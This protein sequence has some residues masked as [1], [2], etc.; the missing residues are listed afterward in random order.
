MNTI[1]NGLSI[2]YSRIRGFLSVI[3]LIVMISASIGNWHSSDELEKE[4]E[5]SLALYGSYSDW[6]EV[7]D[8]FPKYGKAVVMDLD[9][10]LSFNVQRRGGTYHADVQ[11]VTEEDTGIMKQIYGGKW[12]WKRRAVLVLVGD[13]R[14]AGSMNGMPHGGGLIRGNGFPGHFCIHFK[15]SRLHI[16]GNEDLAHRIM[17]YKASG[18][19]ED[20][21]SG[22]TKEEVVRILFT[23]M[24]QEE[25]SITVRT[26]YFENSGDLADFLNKAS[27]ISRIRVG[28]VSRG[29]GD[30]VNVSLG[31]EFKNGKKVSKKEKTVNTV[32]RR[33]LGWRVDYRSVQS[34]L[35]LDGE[36]VQDI[37]GIAG[38]D[39][40]DEGVKTAR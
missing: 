6:Q 37:P 7:K 9:T 34:L 17:I 22:S 24:D 15:G 31:V 32:F 1:S 16:N 27:E 18:L 30:F 14:I 29:K 4:R 35:T 40:E 8:I 26:L 36:I 12:S 20:M 19:L 39:L 5:E 10:G 11:P 25:L 33:D 38:E 3:V 21:I 13:R 2:K 28:Q 23:A